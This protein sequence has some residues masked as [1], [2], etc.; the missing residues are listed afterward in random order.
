MAYT[1]YFELLPPSG[2][3]ANH[4][5]EGSAGMYR[6]SFLCPHAFQ[7]TIPE[8]E[9][10]KCRLSVALVTWQYQRIQQSHPSWEVLV[11]CCAGGL[12]VV[13]PDACTKLTAAATPPGTSPS[14]AVWTGS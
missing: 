4:A 3:T 2:Y 9:E 11:I 7:V 13:R 1:N 12:S 6:A 10:S 14:A 8:V 5:N